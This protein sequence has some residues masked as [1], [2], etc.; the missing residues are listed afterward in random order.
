[1]RRGA[2]EVGVS[3]GEAMGGEVGALASGGATR[4]VAGS[5]AH[6]R[7]RHGAEEAGGRDVRQCEVGRRRV[8]SRGVD[9]VA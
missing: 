1:V 2:E 3:V 7:G 5:G 6:R 9:R 4:G 8:R